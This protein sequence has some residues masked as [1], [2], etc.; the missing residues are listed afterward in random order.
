MIISIITVSVAVLGFIFTYIFT[1]DLRAGYKTLRFIKQK[2]EQENID[3]GADFFREVLSS[4][5]KKGRINVHYSIQPNNKKNDKK[6]NPIEELKRSYLITGESGCGKSTFLRQDYLYHSSKLLDKKFPFFHFYK[7]LKTFSLY[8]SSHSLLNLAEGEIDLIEKKCSELPISHVSLYLDG[9]D[10]LGEKYEEKK[11]LIEKLIK[12]VRL[13]K[14]SEIKIACRSNFAIKHSCHLL[15][16]NVH[17][18]EGYDRLEINHWESQALVETSEEV[19]SNK[20]LN[21]TINNQSK[22]LSNKAN[23]WKKV[24][25]SAINDNKKYFADAPTVDK[26]LINSPLILMLFLYVNLFTSSE[27]VLSKNI[28]KYE[29][30]DKF[31][32]ALGTSCGGSIKDIEKEKELI[33]NLAFRNY[34]MLLNSSSQH[35]SSSKEGGIDGIKYLNRLIKNS[36]TSDNEIS[37][38]HFSFYDFFIAYYYQ[39]NIKKDENDIDTNINVLGAEY[40][41]EISDFIT[42]SLEKEQSNDKIAKAMC[43]VYKTIINKADEEKYSTIECFLVKKEIAFRLGRLRYSSLDIRNVVSAFL[44]NIYYKDN[45]TY[46]GD[47][48]AEIHLAMLKRWVAIAG[49]LLNTKD[50]EEI[51]IDYIKKMVCNRY[52]NNIDDLANR[53]QTLVFYG[54]V[55][56]TSGLDYRDEEPD[57]KCSISIKKRIN[58][59]RNIND[60]SSYHLLARNLNPRDKDLKFY[61]FRAFDL[62]SIYCLLRFHKGKNDMIVE[63]LSKGEKPLKISDI[64]VEFEEANPEREAL[65]IALRNALSKEI[66]PDKIDL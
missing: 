19:L 62:A 42:D 54:D 59:L 16:D 32:T 52:T 47:E 13:V 29:L 18:I 61:C 26:C 60:D 64:R 9:L 46:K 45:Y 28:T 3:A 37:F 31:I 65:L 50:G 17:I 63:E 40:S 8:L 2:T 27:I 4:E 15:L 58:R 66:L 20:N 21:K 6:V 39:M 25:L 14:K 1:K 22:E 35:L 7:R 53:S 38:I 24:F 44:K 49:S 48:D 23:E 43:D 33:A 51:E 55:T 36:Q 5:G 12:T 34:S 30:Y 10:E 11:K 41:N 56:S 57:T